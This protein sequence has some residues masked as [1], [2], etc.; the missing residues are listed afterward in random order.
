MI[1][2]QNE[3][4]IVSE[5]DSHKVSLFMSLH[6]SKLSQ[7]NDNYNGTEV[8]PGFKKK[9][10]LIVIPELS[11]LTREDIALVT[12][13]AATRRSLRKLRTLEEGPVP[14]WLKA[15]RKSPPTAK[16]A[17]ASIGVL[18]ELPL[19]GTVAIGE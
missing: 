8:V 5:F 15:W 2:E 9:I 18:G 3:Q 19:L 13:S 6:Q 11:S 17:R 7:V 1:S 4:I 12:E 14:T 10:L 16:P